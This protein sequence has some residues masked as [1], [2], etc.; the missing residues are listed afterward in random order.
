MS[1]FP[2]PSDPSYPTDPDAVDRCCTRPAPA[3]LHVAQVSELET[4]CFPEFRPLKLT[5]HARDVTFVWQAPGTL[6]VGVVPGNPQSAYEPIYSLTGW[7]NG[8]RC[9]FVLHTHPSWYSFCIAVFDNG[10]PLHLAMG[11]PLRLHV[12]QDCDTLAHWH[13]TVFSNWVNGGNP[14]GRQNAARRMGLLPWKGIRTWVGVHPPF[15]CTLSPVTA[16]R[17]CQSLTSP[18]SE[19]PENR[20]RRLEAQR[21]TR[22]FDSSGW[23][24]ESSL[25]PKHHKDQSRWAKR[26]QCETPTK[27]PGV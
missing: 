24:T 7:F 8:C 1:L 19:P 27:W 11:I 26:T 25:P 14:G 5:A 15:S 12:C 10:R 6:L 21:K 16:D 2:S 20:Y 4:L 9:G 13:L 22:L 18:E 17:G 3:V 23:S